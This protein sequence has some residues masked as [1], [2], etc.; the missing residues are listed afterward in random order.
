MAGSLMPG[1][2]RTVLHRVRDR[3]ADLGDDQQPAIGR[4]R[5]GPGQ[6]QQNLQFEVLPAGDPVQP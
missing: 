5:L 3:T 1:P 4:V 2:V 6:L